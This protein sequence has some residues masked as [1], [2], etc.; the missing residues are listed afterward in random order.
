MSSRVVV[1]KSVAE[2]FGLTVA[3]AMWKSRPV[4]ASRVGGIGDQ[5]VDGESGILI[6]DP[7][8][9]A[10][11]GAA[12]SGLLGQPQRALE[13]GNA[14]RE[15]VR[16]HFLGPRQLTQYFEFVRGLVGDR[17]LSELVEKPSLPASDAPKK[18]YQRRRKAAR[19]AAADRP[20]AAAQ[21]A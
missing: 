15:R 21:T 18:P 10:G 12:L 6:D 20:K 17:P 14:A 11:F 16:E 2:G 5:I 19:A 1:Q 13:I 4:V 3:E 8:D 7:H 9:L